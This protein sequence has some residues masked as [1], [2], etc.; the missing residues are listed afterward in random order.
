M[1]LHLGP[2]GHGLKHLDAQ[3]E[4]PRSLLVFEE[5]GCRPLGAKRIL[6]A[7]VTK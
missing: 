2:I 6:E 4:E 5:P 3:L 7:L 1:R